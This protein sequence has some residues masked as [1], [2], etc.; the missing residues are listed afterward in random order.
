M[1]TRMPMVDYLVLDAGDEHLVARSCTNCQ[2]L[3]FDRRNACAHCGRR[4]FAPRRLGND[5]TLRA[6]TIV[7][8]AAPGVPTPYVSTV[9]DLDGGG[10]VKA[11]LV[12]VDPEPAGIALGMKVRMTTFTAGT[13][14]EGTEAVAFGYEKA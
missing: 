7:H 9:V 10:V 11:N 8:R 1:G 6:F 5:G 2:A 13:D 12:G 14:D 4:E 3:Y